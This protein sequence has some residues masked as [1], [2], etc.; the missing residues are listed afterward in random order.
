M[1]T[2]FTRRTTPGVSGEL[3]GQRARDERGARH[4]RLLDGF[5]G[6]SRGV[7]VR[8]V[9]DVRSED[10]ARERSVAHRSEDPVQRDDKL[11]GW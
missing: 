8:G 10:D 9:G 5:V 7:L 3:L 6:K 4:V 1:H 2:L 11:S